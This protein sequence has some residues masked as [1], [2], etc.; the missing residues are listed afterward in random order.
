MRKII[1]STGALALVA[2]LGALA[3]GQVAQ[4]ATRTNATV[5][6]HKT[7]LGA[8]LVSKSGRTLYLFGRDRNGKSACS[9]SCAAYWPPLLSQGK[10]T[11][12]PG[13]K[14]SLLATT[15]RANGTLQVTY[16]RHPL[17]TY[18]LDKGA[19]QTTGEGVSAFGA[20]WY[21][22][23]AK[24]AAIVRAQGTPTT[25]TPTTSTPYPTYP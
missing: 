20:K 16:N 13:V 10:A 7:G 11:A 22:V 9:G 14:A 17:Y 12:G 23:S 8:V 15:R 6:L 21:A 5:A 18:V 2:A 4:S 3:A 24:G 25:T 19:G 1:I